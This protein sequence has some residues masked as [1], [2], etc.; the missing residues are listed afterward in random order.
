[1]SNIFFPICNLLDV[2]TRDAFD[3]AD[4]NSMQH[5]NHIRYQRFLCES[6]GELSDYIIGSFEV[7]LLVKQSIFLFHAPDE[8]LSH[9]FPLIR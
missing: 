9:I 7:P 8:Y 2:F 6:G 1:M 3:I 4:P 5:V